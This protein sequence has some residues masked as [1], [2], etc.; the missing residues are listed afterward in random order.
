MKRIV[1][2]LGILLLGA[3]LFACAPK[4]AAVEKPI[5]PEAITEEAKITGKEPWQV[6][7]EKTMDGAWK[8]GRLVIHSGTT[9]ETRAAVSKA[10]KSK[11]GIE[12]EW[13]A[14]TSSESANKILTERRAGIYHPDLLVGGAGTAITVLKPAEVLQPVIPKF[15]LPEVVDVK[16][17]YENKYQFADKDN[18]VLYLNL[19]PSSIVS[20][21][22]N[23][24]MREE[25]KSFKDLLNPKWKDKRIR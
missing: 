23:L 10:V 22:S 11:F 2:M 19:S 12:I 16:Y 18:L 1:L 7:W 6:E 13:I 21:N 25:L 17:W 24:V 9:P 20:A 8:E 5:S 15:I 4:G 14:M 3:V